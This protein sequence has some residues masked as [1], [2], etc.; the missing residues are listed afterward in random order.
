[1]E[2]SAYIVLLRKGAI[3]SGICV[4][5]TNFA[6]FPLLKMDAHVYGTRYAD[7]AERDPYVTALLTIVDWHKAMAAS[8][9]SSG[10]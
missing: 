8:S 7:K 1:M 5:F 6:T 3:G 9:F 10:R 2:P 4:A